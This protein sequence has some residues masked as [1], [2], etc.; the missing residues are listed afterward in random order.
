MFPMPSFILFAFLSNSK[1]LYLLCHIISI[2]FNYFIY[3]SLEGCLIFNEKQKR[4][5][6]DGREGGEFQKEVEGKETIIMIYYVRKKSFSL[7]G[8]NQ[9][10]GL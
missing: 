8:K 3:N 5:V 7:K 2:I 1:V 6:S 4:R 10:I 9:Q